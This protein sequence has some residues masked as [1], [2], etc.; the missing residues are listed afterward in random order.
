ML[1]YFRYHVQVHQSGQLRAF[2]K[3]GSFVGCSPNDVL[4]PP[5]E[6]QLRTAVVTLLRKCMNAAN[7]WGDSLRLMSEN[8]THTLTQVLPSFRE[9]IK[10]SSFLVC[11]SDILIPD[12]TSALRRNAPRISSALTR[13]FAWHIVFFT[14]L[15]NHKK[16]FRKNPL[17]PF[18]LN[19]FDVVP[20]SIQ[21]RSSSSRSLRVN[22][23]WN[24][25]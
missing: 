15:T 7:E 17:Q 10:P 16:P 22:P 3:T 13:T 6:K 4:H 1:C 5:A 12:Y 14:L 9:P 20:V 11:T 2:Q 25:Y 24:P 19:N 23:P 21:K 8:H 18:H